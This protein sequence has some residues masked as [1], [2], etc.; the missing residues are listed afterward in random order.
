MIYEPQQME[1]WTSVGSSLNVTGSHIL[2]SLNIIG[3]HNLIKNNVIRRLDFVG[4]G[5]VWLEG[6]CH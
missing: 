5:M 2:S 6:E 4:V 3:P 1:K